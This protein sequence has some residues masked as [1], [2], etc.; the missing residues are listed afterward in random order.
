MTKQ[1]NV[2]QI[3]ITGD[4]IDGAPKNF[5]LESKGIGQFELKEVLQG[6]CTSKAL[7]FSFECGICQTKY[8]SIDDATF[9][10]VSRIV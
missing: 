6:I 7:D 4:R 2:I 9:C 8:G 10:C 1:F 5:K 3:K